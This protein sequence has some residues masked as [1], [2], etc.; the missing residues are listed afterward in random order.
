MI[1][2]PIIAAILFGSQYIPQKL[3]GN[4][5]TEYYNL[6]MILGA[7]AGSVF[8]FLIISFIGGFAPIFLVPFFLSFVG[9]IFWSLGNRLSLVGINN[10]G[11][12][13][14][15]VILN[16]VSVISFIFGILFFAE[17]PNLYLFIGIPFLMGGAIIVSLLGESS[18][19]INKLGVVSIFIATIFISINNVLSIDAITA[20]YFNHPVISIF[21]SV[22]CVCLGAA[23]GALLFNLT[24]SKL[25]E[26]I[27]QP[28]RTHLYAIGAG[29]IWVAGFE[30]TTYILAIPELGLSFG[31]PIIQ[32]VMI[33]VSALWGLLY[34][35]E[36]VGRKKIGLYVTGTGI[37][38]LGVILFAF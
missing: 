3:A 7:V 19:Q 2:F 9:G 26:W 17:S 16:F 38:I 11:M 23:I 32:S 13:K 24:P 8:T 35:K 22:M 33:V 15:T 5:K 30:I 31:V 18:G 29:F 21:T 34:F 27:A 25:R 6:T 1:I 12:A 28:R 20:G 36:I 10:I 14:T 37:T 4:V